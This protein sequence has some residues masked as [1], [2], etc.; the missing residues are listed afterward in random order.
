MTSTEYL[1]GVSDVY[2]QELDELNKLATQEAVYR[3]EAEKEVSRALETRGQ[4][5]FQMQGMRYGETQQDMQMA[6]Q[7]YEAGVSNMWGGVQTMAG[8]AMQVGMNNQRMAEL[9][10]IYGTGTSD[11]TPFTR[12]STATIK[13]NAMN[14]LGRLDNPMNSATPTMNKVGSVF[15]LSEANSKFALYY[16]IPR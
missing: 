10:K 8:A 12:P 1:S 14:S 15:N 11:T 5:D 7:G 16:N 13:S 2:G 9:D 4:Y 6:G 3:L